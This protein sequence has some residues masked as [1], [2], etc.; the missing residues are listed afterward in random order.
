MK[1][2]KRTKNVI[3]FFNRTDLNGPQDCEYK[4]LDNYCF[5]I[6]PDF[7]YDFSYHQYGKQYYINSESASIRKNL[8]WISSKC[9]YAGLMEE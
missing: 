3:F 9:Q 8:I 4:I 7:Y 1:T 5:P 6:N 2:G